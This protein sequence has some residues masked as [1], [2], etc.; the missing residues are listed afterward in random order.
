MPPAV[1]P[2]PRMT[3]GGEAAEEAPARFVPTYEGRGEAADGS[4]DEPLTFRLVLVTDEGG[5]TVLVIEKTTNAPLVRSCW[6][7]RW[8][9][10]AA[11]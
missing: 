4:K 5:G 3:E 9:R 1:P 6:R 2:F 10:W 7:G 8:G 11:Q